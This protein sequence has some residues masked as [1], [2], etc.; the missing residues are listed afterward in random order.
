[1]PNIQDI[2]NAIGNSPAGVYSPAEDTFLMVDALSTLSLRGKE[3][4]D[5]GTGSGVLGLFCAERGAN[6]T[7]VDIEDSALETAIGAACKLKLTIKAAKSD[8]F[9][10]V[11]GR[12]D[13]VLFNPPYLPS[14]EVRDRTVDGGVE[15]KKLIDR[16]LKELPAHLDPSGFALL[17][18]SSLNEP[19]VVIDGHP[20]FLF[21]VSAKRSLF[22]EELQVLMCK[23]RNLS[24]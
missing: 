2:L 15:G 12:F 11:A 4:L 24:R 6:V 14:S 19:R 17:L 5:L 20:E 8:I 13:V 1:M 3:V 18:V 10:N 23:L 7:V 21:T 9:S 22:F 16:F